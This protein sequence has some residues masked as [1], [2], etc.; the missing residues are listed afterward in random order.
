LNQFNG[1]ARNFCSQSSINNFD[2]N[3]FSILHSWFSIPRVADIQ[4]KDFETTREQTNKQT[5]G[6]YIKELARPVAPQA[7]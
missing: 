6:F 2:N 1:R 5:N 7:D 3:H 4:D